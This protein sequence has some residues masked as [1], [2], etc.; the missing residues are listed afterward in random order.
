MKY[1]KD[2]IKWTEHSKKVTRFNWPHQN[3][4]AL[5]FAQTNWRIYYFN[6]SS[7]SFFSTYGLKYWYGPSINDVG[8][9]EGG[10]RVKNWSKLPTDST[11]KV[12]TWVRGV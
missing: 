6:P 10:E 12:P 1:C 2:L 7:F 11:N 8:N 4:S 5:I 9:S 3:F